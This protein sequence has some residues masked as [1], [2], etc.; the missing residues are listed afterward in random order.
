MGPGRPSVL[1]W[2]DQ[3]ATG[4]AA[5]PSRTGRTAGAPA[6]PRSRG[7]R[8]PRPRHGGTWVAGRA[9]Q[10]RVV[11]G[12]AAPSHRPRPAT[13]STKPV[14]FPHAASATPPR[15]RRHGLVTTAALSSWATAGVVLPVLSGGMP[16]GVRRSA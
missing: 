13:P 5:A 6:P 16:P 2:R 4:N 11:W 14:S 10:A 3:A 7:G 1:V 8:R 9:R 12:P 15:P